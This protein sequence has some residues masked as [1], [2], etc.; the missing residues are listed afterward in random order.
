M[1]YRSSVLTPKPRVIFDP[2]NS[3]HRLDFAHFFKYNKWSEPCRFFLED[4]YE[5]IPAMIKDKL[6]THYMRHSL[7]NI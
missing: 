3:K 4:P 6:I 5:D 2:Q 1:S 7:D